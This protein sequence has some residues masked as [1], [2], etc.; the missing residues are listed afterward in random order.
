MSLIIQDSGQRLRD[1]LVR[2]VLV[3]LK[4]ANGAHLGGTVLDVRHLQ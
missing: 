3:I 4:Q 2:E 1:E